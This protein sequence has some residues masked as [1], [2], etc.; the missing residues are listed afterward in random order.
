MFEG[1]FSHSII[2]HAIQKK[3][4]EIEFVNIRKFGEGKHKLVDD[5]PYGGG[6]GM[7]M[8]VDILH[9]A[10]LSMQTKARGEKS[11]LLTPQGKTFVQKDA[12][13]LSKLSHLI[14]ICGHYEGIDAR[15]EK[16]V[17]DKYSIGDFITTGGEIPAMII[18]DSIIRLLPEVLKKGVT[19]RESFQ[20]LL[21]YPQYTKPRSYKSLEVPKVLLSGDHRKIEKFKKEQ[22]EKI[23]YRLRP[24]LIERE[25]E[26][27]KGKH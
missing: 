17:D 16:F 13:K 23:T 15:F 21:E 14:L 18:I 2:K 9:K 19:N 7:I 24:D 8:R 10:L 4:V 27:G 26:E 11:I 25:K 1:P 6:T 5:K 20:N 22:S 3:I 12:I